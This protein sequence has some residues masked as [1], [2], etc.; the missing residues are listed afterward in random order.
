MEE[1]QI[2]T[3]KK[4]EVVDITD[5]VADAVKETAGQD[6]LIHLFLLHTTVALTIADLD[7]GTDQDLLDALAELIPK[8]H[9]RHPHDPEHVPDDIL[10]SLIG[11]SLTVPM[12]AG[13]LVLGT[14]QRIVLIELRESL[15]NSA[16]ANASATGSNNA[17]GI[18]R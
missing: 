14:R 5:R 10:S 3:R 16:C 4:R 17:D 18:A 6:G 12:A 8:L 11:T 2:A 13:Q 9:Y 1:L 15:P 7:P